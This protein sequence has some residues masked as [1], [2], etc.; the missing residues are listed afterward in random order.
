MPSPKSLPAALLGL[1]FACPAM[2]EAEGLELGQV[3]I[4][5]EERSGENPSVEDA[6][7]RLAQVPGGTN[8]VDL[9]ELLQRSLNSKPAPKAA[10]KPPPVARKTTKSGGRKAA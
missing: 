1:A 6:K 9:T 10:D 4:Q 8:V 2:A 5:A 7:S 3:L